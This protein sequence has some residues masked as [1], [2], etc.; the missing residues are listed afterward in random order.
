MLRE[1]IVLY[2]VYSYNRKIWFQSLLLHYGLYALGIWLVLTVLGINIYYLGFLGALS[3]LVGSI[4]LLL[5]RLGSSEMRLISNAVQYLNLLLLVVT[6]SLALYGDFFNERIR[7]YLLS[8]IYLKPE[9][10]IFSG[11]SAFFAALFFI[12][13]FVLYLPL[14]SMVHFFAKYYT[15]DKIRWGGSD[16]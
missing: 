4:L 10:E 7:D 9:P 13:L 1:I 2:Q 16:H 3:V 11:N 6:S 8:V 12:E 5:T 14:S 15:W